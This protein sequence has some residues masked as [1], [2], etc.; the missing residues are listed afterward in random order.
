MKPRRWL[1]LIL[2]TTLAAAIPGSLPVPAWAAPLSSD[3]P[4]P[5]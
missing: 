3:C 1:V 5:L 4:A 2:L